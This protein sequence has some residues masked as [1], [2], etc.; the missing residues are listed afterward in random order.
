VIVLVRH[1]EPVAATDRRYEQN[2]RPLAEAGHRE[3]TGSP[4]SGGRHLLECNVVALALNGIAPD[5]S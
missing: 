1:A 2:D 3:P 4:R 5:Q